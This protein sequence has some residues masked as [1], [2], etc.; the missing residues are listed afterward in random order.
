MGEDDEDCGEDVE[1]SVTKEQ[2]DENS[3]GEIRNENDKRDVVDRYAEGGD[4]WVFYGLS[5]YD[6]P[7]A[8]EEREREWRE[9][10]N[11]KP[12]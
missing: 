10:Q 12:L 4:Y 7:S 3:Q 2:P 6:S 5:M 1:G 8:W 11:N 9:Q